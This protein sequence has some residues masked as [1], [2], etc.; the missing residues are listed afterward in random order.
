M[1]SSYHLVQQMTNQIVELEQQLQSKHE[2]QQP[3]LE[4]SNC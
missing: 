4:C 2:Q 1:K 3:L